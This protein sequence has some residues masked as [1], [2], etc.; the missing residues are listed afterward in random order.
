MDQRYQLL[1]Y[2]TKLNHIIKQQDG[3]IS[4]LEE[5][6]GIRVDRSDELIF[7]KSD[8]DYLTSHNHCEE[9]STRYKC[10]IK[11]CRNIGSWFYNYGV[12]T[13]HI[14][15][16]HAYE[17]TGW[18]TYIEDLYY[19]KNQVD[20]I[21]EESNRRLEVAKNLSSQLRNK[22]YIENEN[23]YLKERIKE[24]EMDVT[25]R[26][27]HKCDSAEKL[28]EELAS[29]GV[30]LA[31]KLMKAEMKVDELKTQVARLVAQPMF[32]ETEAEKR[33]EECY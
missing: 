30:Q 26:Q 11:G 24:L 12:C 15:N 10:D 5:Q 3:R 18:K 17:D 8:N 19:Y 4:V 29:A 21:K 13:I 6:H 20:K 25:T 9:T 33:A 14:C 32:L 16:R 28:N 1:S 22:I 7:D 23:K 27:C 31:A 2:I